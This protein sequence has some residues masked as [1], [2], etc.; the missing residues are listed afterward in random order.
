[1]TPRVLALVGLPGTGKTALAQALATH[2]MAVLL[3]GGYA[4]SLETSGLA[5]ERGG[6]ACAYRC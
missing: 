1:M 3:R 2:R 4:G 6:N 5:D